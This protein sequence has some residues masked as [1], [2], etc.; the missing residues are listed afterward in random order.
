MK[1]LIHKFK[2][3]LALLLTLAM[4]VGI[5]PSLPGRAN[6]VKA[7]TGSGT[8]GTPSVTAFATKTQL[9]DAFAPDSDGNAAIIGK[10]VF[11][12]NSNGNS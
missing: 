2:K 4:V 1:R 12:K 5:I 8:G 9:M 11:G 7:A 6:E 10:L 3:G